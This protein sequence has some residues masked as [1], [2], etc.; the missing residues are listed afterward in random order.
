MRQNPNLIS[1]GGS[2]AF[3][4]TGVKERIWFPYYDRKDVVSATAQ[5]LTFFQ[6]VGVDDL[7]SNFEGSGAFPAGQGFIIHTMRI[8]PDMN[9]RADDVANLLKA[10]SL[11]F[12]IENAKKYAQAP[13]WLYPAGV[14]MVSND[15]LGAAAAAAPANSKAFGSNGIQSLNNAFRFKLPVKLRPQ[16]QFKVQ[17]ITP[18]TISLSATLPVYI[19]MEGILERNLQ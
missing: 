19:V 11:L 9:A 18:A 17:L 2:S 12:T 16:Q 14:G 8:V 15:S 7:V 10:S 5:T 13:S 3:S 6:T 4:G 1:T